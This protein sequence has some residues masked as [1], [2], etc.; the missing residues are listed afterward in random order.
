MSPS[1]PVKLFDLLGAATEQEAADKWPTSRI[2]SRLAGDALQLVRYLQGALEFHAVRPGAAPDRVGLRAEVVVRNP[3][4]PQIV[5]LVLTQLPNFE[6]Y[7]LST[8]G[9]PGSPDYAPA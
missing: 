1:R 7:L 9:T 6:F 3:P 5:P 2:W 4:V 8:A